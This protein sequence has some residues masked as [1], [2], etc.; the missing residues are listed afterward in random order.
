MV[1]TQILLD[2]KTYQDLKRR[3]A[4]E[5][6]SLSAVIRE[7]LRAASPKVERNRK[8]KKKLTIEDFTFIGSF[9]LGHPDNISERHDE[10]LGEGRW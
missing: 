8:G 9:E 2:E 4:K 10:V 6:K 1:R 3:A 5:K 7:V